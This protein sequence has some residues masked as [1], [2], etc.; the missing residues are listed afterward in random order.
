MKDDE[1]FERLSED[2]R[3]LR[4]E[5]EDD[6]AF[7][8]I[9]THVRE[10]TQRP[11]TVFDLLVRWRFRIAGALGGVALIAALSFAAIPSTVFTDSIDSIARVSLMTEDFYRVAR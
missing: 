10:H 2:A 4:Y 6:M 7:G 1:F 5:P 9:R 3:R 8:R 11:L